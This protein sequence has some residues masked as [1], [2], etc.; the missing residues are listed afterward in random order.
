MCKNMINGGQVKVEGEAGQAATQQRHRRPSGFWHEQNGNDQQSVADRRILRAQY[1]AVKADI[2]ECKQDADGFDHVLGNIEGLYSAVRRPREQIADA[3]ALYDITA[4]LLASVKGQHCQSASQLVSCI[5][6]NFGTDA[7]AADERNVP[8]MDWERLGHE[9]C[10]IFSEAP[11]MTTMIGPLE[12]RQKQRKTPHRRPRD[13]AVETVRPEELKES[14]DSATMTDKNMEIMFRILKR[15]KSV[16]LEEIVL[17]RCSFA[18]T[19]ENI[20]A[21][22]FLVKEGRA[23]ISIKDGRHIVG[24]MNFP[25]QH[26]REQGKGSMNQFVFRFD[27]KDWQG[28]KEIVEEGREKMPHRVNIVEGTRAKQLRKERIENR[29]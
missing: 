26:Q 13:R 25:S 8:E 16:Y 22:S 20:F 27:F 21:L 17:N 28:M 9:A 24:P 3:E 29:E 19:V 10:S 5:I 11:G 7:V 4:S 1:Q 15:L 18:Q 14:T 23:E 12:S 2:A 6:K